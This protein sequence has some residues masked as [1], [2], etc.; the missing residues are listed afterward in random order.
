MINK[1]LTFCII[2]PTQNAGWHSQNILSLSSMSASI[3]KVFSFQSYTWLESFY[4][5]HKSYM[6]VH[7]RKC[8]L[9]N[10][11]SAAIIRI[12]VQVRISPHNISNLPTQ[13]R[14]KFK[15][16]KNFWYPISFRY[17]VRLFF[18]SDMSRDPIIRSL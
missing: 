7:C 3:R 8:L 18:G 2:A 4:F 10:T 14:T 6:T 9:N 17:P 5:W 11:V 16:K 12:I 1:Y 13:T 15:K